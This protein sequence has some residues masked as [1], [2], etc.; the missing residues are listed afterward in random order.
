MLGV[1]SFGSPV[2]MATITNFELWSMSEEKCQYNFC[3]NAYR[4]R[5]PI[6]AMVFMN[7]TF[8]LIIFISV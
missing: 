7:S 4:S 8:Q 3:F 6:T 2:F 1:R 5:K